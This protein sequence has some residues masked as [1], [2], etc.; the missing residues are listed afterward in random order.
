MELWRI[1]GKTDDEGS[2]RDSESRSGISEIEVSMIREW[3]EDWDSSENTKAKKED[4]EVE[5]ALEE[6]TEVAVGVDENEEVSPEDPDTA[7]SGA[8]GPKYIFADYVFDFDEDAS[9]EEDADERENTGR[10]VRSGRDNWPRHNR[11]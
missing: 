11:A 9:T 2:G 1:T 10:P 5:N 6:E 7:I 8:G 3:E 4:S